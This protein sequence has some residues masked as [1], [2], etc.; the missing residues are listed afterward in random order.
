[1][2]AI[3]VKTTVILFICLSI[4]S[5]MLWKVRLQSSTFN[6]TSSTPLSE[7]EA[8]EYSPD[9]SNA[10]LISAI[11]NNAEFKF[12]ASARDIYAYISGFQ[13]IFI[14]T[15]FTIKAKELQEL[16]SS[17][18]CN[19]SLQALKIPLENTISTP[20]W[21]K[22]SEAKTVMTCSGTTETFGQTVYIDMTNTDTY[23]VYIEG[24][25]H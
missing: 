8:N 20:A 17:T 21:W 13:D 5:F 1:M 23:I 11:E 6:S 22:L 24:E 14:Q 16:I 4:F 3:S 9:L 18:R 19:K 12:P 15:K 7:F 25:T 2:K 10:E